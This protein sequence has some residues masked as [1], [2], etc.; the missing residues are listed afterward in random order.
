MRHAF[1]LYFRLGMKHIGGIRCFRGLDKILP[2]VGLGTEV[3][4][5]LSGTDRK[6]V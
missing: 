6:S 2:E 5:G 1:E 3:G 4:G